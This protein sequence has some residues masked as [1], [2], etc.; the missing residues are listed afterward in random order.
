MV[1][2]QLVRSPI[3]ANQRIQ[4]AVTIHIAKRYR[5]RVCTAAREAIGDGE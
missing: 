1:Q 3:V 5:V 2:K 4:V